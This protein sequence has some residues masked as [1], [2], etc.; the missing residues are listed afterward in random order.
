MTEPQLPTLAST[1]TAGVVLEDEPVAHWRAR[2]EAAETE[3]AARE[4]EL[5]RAQECIATLR[6]ARWS[7]LPV[8]AA[9][10]DEA[11]SRVRVESR[12]LSSELHHTESALQDASATA[13]ALG[14]KAEEYLQ[15]LAICSSDN[16]AAAAPAPPK[17]PAAAPVPTAPPAAPHAAPRRRQVLQEATT[18][19]YGVAPALAKGRRSHRALPAAS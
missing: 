16:V 9:L 3:L 6:A 11:S 18:Q 8:A 2:A 1:A 10:A 13:F 7:T 15:R 4:T 19:A 5:R 17:P 12:L 14:S